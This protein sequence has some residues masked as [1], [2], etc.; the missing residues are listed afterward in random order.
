MSK[1]NNLTKLI[2]LLQDR[3]RSSG[4]AKST[5]KLGNTIYIDTD[6]YSTEIL[7]S[8]LTLSISEFNQVP[9][10]TFF[11]L[12]DDDFVNLF[13]EVLVEGATIYALA[14]QALI[15]RGREFAIVDNGLNF[16]PPTISNMLNTQYQAAM[17]HHWEKLKTIKASIQQ[18]T[19]KKN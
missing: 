19:F 4:K 14:S 5:D 16:N 8:F 17:V 2:K 10:F 6:I 9:Y 3:L 1:E 11:T 18:L 15:E 13:S 7:E 12:D